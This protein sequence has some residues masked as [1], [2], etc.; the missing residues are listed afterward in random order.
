MAPEVNMMGAAPM[1]NT[2]QRTIVANRWIGNLAISI[3]LPMFAPGY[4]IK[5]FL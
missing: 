3:N 5:E 4:E 1:E 2:S